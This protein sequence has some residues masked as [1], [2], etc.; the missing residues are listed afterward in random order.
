MGW[1][2]RIHVAFPSIFSEHWPYFDLHLATPVGGA[3]R[4][5]SRDVNGSSCPLE[6]AFHPREGAPGFWE[7]QKSSW[8]W[9]EIFPTFFF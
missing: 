9:L 1:I 5:P 6:G 7:Q 4:T 8:L 2:L 3:A